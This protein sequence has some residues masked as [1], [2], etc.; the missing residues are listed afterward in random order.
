VNVIRHHDPIIK[1]I[2]LFVKMKQGFCN[3]L[4]YFR[5]AEMTFTCSS[6]KISFDFPAQVALD[7]FRLCSRGLRPKAAHCFCLFMLE[8]EQYFFWQ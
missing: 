8:P 6:V 7:F 3:H 2:V 5:T 4:R 1:Q